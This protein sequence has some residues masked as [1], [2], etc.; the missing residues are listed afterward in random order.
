MAI[1]KVIISNRQKEI[2]IPTGIRMLIRR[3]CQAVLQTEGFPEEAEVSVSF[4]SNEEIKNLNRD[5]RN[6]D[7]VTDVLS[8][9][10]GENG[11]YDRNP[12]S[13]VLLLGDIVIS[14]QKAEQQAE[15]YGH[16]LQR[17]VAYLT[18]HSMLHLLGYDHVN[19]GLEQVRM[20][21]REETVLAKL[22]LTRDASYVSEV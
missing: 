22:G 4:I 21:E 16:S 1:A 11:V 10:L 20:R 6:V 15:L 12:E 17:E 13:G 14:M 19:G 2:K 9:P 8:F 7:S 18:V 5:F 3:C